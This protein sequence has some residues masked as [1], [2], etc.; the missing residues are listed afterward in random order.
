MDDES[1]TL[2]LSAFEARYLRELLMQPS[3][4]VESVDETRAR[5][6]LLRALGYEPDDD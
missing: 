1:K 2:K 5:E 4:R 6:R 3:V